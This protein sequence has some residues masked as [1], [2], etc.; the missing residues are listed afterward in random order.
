MVIASDP[1]HVP[2]GRH[3]TGSPQLTLAVTKR[4]SEWTSGRRVRHRK[5]PSP[6]VQDRPRWHPRQRR[7]VREPL[8]GSHS[9]GTTK[10]YQRASTV[11]GTAGGASADRKRSFAWTPVRRSDS[12]DGRNNANENLPKRIRS[13]R[14]STLIEIRST[15]RERPDRGR[16]RSVDPALRRTHRSAPRAAVRVLTQFLVITGTRS[17][18]V[19]AGSRRTPIAGRVR[20]GGRSDRYDGHE[21]GIYLRAGSRR[22]PIAGRVRHGGWSDRYNRPDPHNRER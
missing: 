19:R 1:S 22:A 20:H 5:L 15:R 16:D 14:P 12:H 17:G 13:P 18:S 2:L 9:H 4:P 10:R 7:G 3:R 8:T 11:P 21:V 6:P